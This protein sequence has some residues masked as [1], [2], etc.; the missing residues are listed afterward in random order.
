MSVPEDNIGT[1]GFS[2]FE[3]WRVKIGDIVYPTLEH[4]YQAAKTDN[5]LHKQRIAACRTPSSAKRM[6]QHVDLVED[7]EL[8]KLIVMWQL[9][10]RKFKPGSEWADRLLQTRG[11]LVEWNYWHDVYWGKC[12]CATHE[13]LG[14]NMLG[15]LLMLIREQLNA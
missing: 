12:T 8:R 14:E 15:R 2:N 3:P 1:L 10:R 7:W 6:G 5:P 13:N 9:L 11:K 4:A